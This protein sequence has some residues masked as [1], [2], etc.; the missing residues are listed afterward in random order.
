MQGK[1][2][3]LRSR[4]GSYAAH[5]SAQPVELRCGLCIGHSLGRT[6]IDRPLDVVTVEEELDRAHVVVQTDP[7]PVLPT[8]TDAPC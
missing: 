4:D 5:A 3:G 6:H 8:R 1:A 7:A 2:T